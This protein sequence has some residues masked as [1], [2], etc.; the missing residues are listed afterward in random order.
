M[1]DRVQERALAGPLK[2]IQRLVPKPLPHCLGFLL[3]VVFLLEGEPS[4]QCEVLSALE[5][6]FMKDLSLVCGVQLSVDSE[7]NH[8]VC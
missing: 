7:C 1:F 5:K 6:V 8:S 2:N 4:S 3:W